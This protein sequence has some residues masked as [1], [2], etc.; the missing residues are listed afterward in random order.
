[1][2]KRSWSCLRNIKPLSVVCLLCNA[3]EC[4]ETLKWFTR[5]Y[6]YKLD[7]TQLSN[8]TT[9][10]DNFLHL[11][12]INR[13]QLIYPRQTKKSLIYDVSSPCICI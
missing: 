6:L 2:K 5:L 4:A 3:F 1:M 9:S 10:C 11:K 12:V 7:N 8:E 13:R